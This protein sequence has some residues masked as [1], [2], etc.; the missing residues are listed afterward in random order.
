[1]TVFVR[2]LMTGATAVVFCEVWRQNESFGA[3][4][5]FGCTSKQLLSMAFERARPSGK[6]KIPVAI[7]LQESDMVILGCVHSHE[8]PEKTHPLLVSQ[9]FH[10]MLGMTKTCA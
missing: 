1:M 9:A 4:I 7:R 8:I 5:L 6:L 10:A 3:F 2:L